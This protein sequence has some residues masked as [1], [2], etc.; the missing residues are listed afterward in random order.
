MKKTVGTHLS[1]F[2]CDDVTGSVLLWYVNGFNEY[3]LIRTSDQN[4]L[5]ECDLVFDVGSVYDH[6]K[7]RYDHHQRNYNETFS[8][9]HNVLLCGCGL[10][11]KHYGNEIIQNVITSLHPDVV[12]TTFQINWLMLKVYNMFILPIDGKDNGID[13]ND[14]PMKYYDYSSLSDRIRRLNYYAEG[15]QRLDKFAEAQQIVQKEFIEIVQFLYDFGLPSLTLVNDNFVKRFKYNDDGKILVLFSKCNWSL[16]LEELQLNDSKKVLGEQWK[17][18]AI[19]KTGCFK[20]LLPFPNNW[21]G[22][23][24]DQLS[25]ECKVEHSIFVHN[26]GFLAV[27]KTLEG[28][29]QMT[30]ISL[31]QL[32]E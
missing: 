3:Q 14:S 9:Q 15:P 17:C 27:N 8:P 31:Q 1:N 6:S 16:I 13:I 28:I 4:V 29:L 19:S 5:N 25:N 2:H 23:R 11:F 18:T 32:I 22:L 10:L 26:S 20:P 7:K 21:R 30:T 24:D 12:L